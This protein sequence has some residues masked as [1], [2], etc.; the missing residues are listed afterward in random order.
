MDCRKTD[1]GSWFC[2]C[3]DDCRLDC[4]LNWRFQEQLMTWET[5]WASRKLVLRLKSIH[6]YVFGSKDVKKICPTSTN[7]LRKVRRCLVNGFV[8][9]L[10]KAFEIDN[11]IKKYQEEI[12]LS[13]FS[14]FSSTCFERWNNIYVV[15]EKFNFTYLIRRHHFSVFKIRD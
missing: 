13:T 12:M 8:P 10:R 14:V 7:Q 5:F 15:V 9:L 3:V 2:V 6:D 4:E 1:N 11:S